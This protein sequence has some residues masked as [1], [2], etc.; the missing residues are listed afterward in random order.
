MADHHKTNWHHILFSTLRAYQTTTKTAIGF[1]PF[2][3]VH[4]IKEVIPIKY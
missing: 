3:L 4:G 1:M 2:H